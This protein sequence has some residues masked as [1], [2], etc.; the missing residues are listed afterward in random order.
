MRIPNGIGPDV[1]REYASSVAM[2]NPLK[3]SYNNITQFSIDKLPNFNSG[4]NHSSQHLDKNVNNSLPV[5]TV[6][7]SRLTK[8]PLHSYLFDK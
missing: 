4:N 3:I 6:L 8:S 7:V 2:P 1:R 5:A